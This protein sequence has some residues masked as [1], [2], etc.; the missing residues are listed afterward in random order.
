MKYSKNFCFRTSFYPIDYTN[1]KKDNIYKKLF[2]RTTEFGG[3]SKVKYITN[4]NIREGIYGIKFIKEYYNYKFKIITNPLVFDK[5]KYYLLYTEKEKISLLKTKKIKQIMEYFKNGKFYSYKYNMYIIKKLL[6]I[7]FLIKADKIVKTKYIDI[8]EPIFNDYLDYRVVN[9][10]LDNNLGNIL[11]RFKYQLRDLKKILIILSNIYVLKNI[12]ATYSYYYDTY[13]DK[14]VPILDLINDDLFLNFFKNIKF[15]INKNNLLYKEFIQLIIN[16]FDK[17]EVKFDIELKKYNSPNISGDIYLNFLSIDNSDI[18]CVDTGH[19]IQ[20]I[21]SSNFVL[22]EWNNYIKLGYFF[23]DEIKNIFYDDNKDIYFINEYND[24]KLKDIYV[25]YSQQNKIFEICD[26]IKTVKILKPTKLD[27]KNFPEPLKN[28]YKLS[29]F[30]NFGLNSTIDVTKIENIVHFPRIMVGN[31]ILLKET[32]I[33]NNYFD[34]FSIFKRKLIEFMS[35]YRIPK[36]VSVCENDYTIFINIDD[37]IDLR[38]LFKKKNN[39]IIFK[40]DIQKY[41]IVKSCGNVYCNEAIISFNNEKLQNINIKV[42]NKLEICKQ[43][44]EW[45]YFE[46]YIPNYEIMYENY[47]EELYLYFEKNK[48]VY[49]FINYKENDI[50]TIRFRLYK[51]KEKGKLNLFLYKLNLKFIIKPYIPE[52]NKY[53]EVIRLVEKHFLYESMLILKT[54]VYFEFNYKIEICLNFIDIIVFKKIKLKKEEIIKYFKNYK[55][56]NNSMYSEIKIQEIKKYLYKNYELKKYI[57]IKFIDNIKLLHEFIHLVC[58]R[59]FGICK[60]DELKIKGICKKRY[61][62]RIYKNDKK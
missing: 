57:N 58:N 8:K 51:Y 23:E 9:R 11:K 14:K 18:I 4:Q 19:N 6:S 29:D 34:K 25:Y 37:E 52:I 22:N 45:F 17:Q 32:W 27:L 7:N 54:L 60:E 12:D 31:I 42:A 43:Q 40:E 61:L 55:I 53:G 59:I 36:Y 21:A 20:S 10:E 13:Y 5:G 44:N 28:I 35:K 48:C 62:E 1:S 39:K 38:Y 33:F 47:L 49:F 15:E 26:S 24:N 41:S 30:I 3:Y 46:I 56:I 16:N 2:Y 50:N